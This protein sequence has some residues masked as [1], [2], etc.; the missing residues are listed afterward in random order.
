MKTH[1]LTS[2]SVWLMPLDD[3]YW[4]ALYIF[5]NLHL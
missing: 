2:L 1:N 3:W 4:D 5:K